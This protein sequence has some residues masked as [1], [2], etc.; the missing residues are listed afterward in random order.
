MAS[1]TAEEGE[2]EPVAITLFTEKAQLF[3]EYPRLV[4]GLNA[5][6]LAHVT[7]LA[8]GAP[9]RSGELRLELSQGPGGSRTLMAAHPTRDGLFIPAGT[10]DAPGQYQA[11][12]VVTSNQLVETFT[13][14]PIVVYADLA[15]AFAAADAEAE[16]EPANVVP[17]LLEQQWKIGLLMKQVEKRSMTRRLQVPG[18]VEA[19]YHGMAVASAPLAG[20]LL[21]PEGG[22]LPRLGERVQKGQ[23]LGILEPPLTTSDAA[24]LLANKTNNDTLEMEFL[25]REFDAQAKALEVEQSLHQSEVQLG[26]AHQ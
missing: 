19:P 16:D 25:M 18:A 9:I 7:V 2:P 4:P 23:I 26:F 24:Q 3:M 22:S 20:R 13:L 11:Q 8:T 1:E 6:F 21:P 17:F 15:S 14:E 10:F 5:R 12:I